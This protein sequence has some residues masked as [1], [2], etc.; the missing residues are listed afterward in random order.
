MQGTKDEPGTSQFRRLWAT[1]VE[2]A[3][4][5]KIM[6]PELI[7]SCRFT[8]SLGRKILNKKPHRCRTGRASLSLGADCWTGRASS[9]DSTRDGEGCS[10][11]RRTLNLVAASHMEK[12]RGTSPGPLRFHGG[13]SDGAGNTVTDEKVIAVLSLSRSAASAS[14]GAPLSHC[15]RAYCSARLV[16]CNISAMRL[17]YLSVM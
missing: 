17:C 13:T 1:S 6:R 12:P 3:I 9:P 8:R 16:S 10:A 11:I 2:R 15:K 14:V 4:S 7:H 5:T